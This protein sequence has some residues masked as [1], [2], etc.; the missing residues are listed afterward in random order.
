MAEETMEN[1]QYDLIFDAPRSSSKSIVFTAAYDHS[2]RHQESQQD[3]SS[4]RAAPSSNTVDS[5]SRRQ[6][7]L[8]KVKAGIR[9][10]SS[11]VIDL[12]IQ[13][14]GQQ[15]AQYVATLAYASSHVDDKASVLA[16]FGKADHNDKY[17]ICFDANSRIPQVSDVDY[18]QTLQQEP[19]IHVNA[20]INFG[21]K[22]Q[23]GSQI[24]LSGR[25]ERSQERLQYV[26][27]QSQ[28]KQCQQE[29]QHENQLL[30]GCRNATF[31]ANLLDKY[32]WTVKYDRLSEEFKNATYQV[33]SV[34]RHLGYPYM[35]ENPMVQDH[36][37]DHKVEIDVS[38]RP[39]L[40]SADVQVSSPYGDMQFHNI[41]VNKYAR[42]LVVAHPT[43]NVAR[44][45]GWSSTRQQ[46]NAYCTIDKTYARTFDNVTYP[47]RIGNVWHVM[48]V[49]NPKLNTDGSYDNLHQFSVLLREDSEG[50]KEV[51]MV[52]EHSEHTLFEIKPVSGKVYG[53]FFV[54][55]EKVQLSTD[56]VYEYQS[57]EGKVIVRVVVLPSGEIR[58]VAP[59]HEF[60][61]LYGRV[62]VQLNVGQIYRNR[63]GGL[64]GVFNGERY[65][66]V[67]PQQYVLR[68]PEIF[69]ATWAL[70]NEGRIG[71]LKQKAEKYSEYKKQII[72][73]NSVSEQDTGR[74]D[75][76]GRLYKNLK[77]SGEDYSSSSSSSSASSSSSESKESVEDCKTERITVIERQG[78]HCF[79]LLPQTAC[80]TG[81]QVEKTKT[82]TAK[83]FCVNK[84]QTSSHWAQM[85]SRGAKPNFANKGNAQEIKYEAPVKCS[86]S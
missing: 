47:V 4:Q 16:Y 14:Q 22:C 72:L 20:Q 53:Y 79:S 44:R 68:D 17:E 71:E 15:P 36:Q 62:R 65:D 46:Q 9:E 24:T 37:Q 86:R 69:A 85:V 26:Q 6:E 33:Y 66:M 76:R 13:F 40:T 84:T 56:K 83:F 25:F 23:S 78:K 74:A 2:D 8:K 59:E 42:T 43:M 38:F 50:Q 1:S 54:N 10:A 12:G 60:E 73:T 77:S 18:R 3:S 41:R 28:S 81:C 45:I 67:T 34:L 49:S 32:S 19:K 75:S 5:Q 63:V 52:L 11:S 61:F 30:S 58:L 51:Q 21:E 39:D 55:G 31:N 80:K 70:S 35:S 48:F 27:K 29:M 64:C 57:K 82:Q 7:F